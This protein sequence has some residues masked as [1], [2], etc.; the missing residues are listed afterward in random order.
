MAQLDARPTGDQKVVASTPA[1]SATFFLGDLDRNIFYGPSLPFRK[2]VVSFWRKRAHYWLTAWT[3]AC[4]VKVW[5]DK[6]T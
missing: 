6:L 5:L 2:A 1:G 3:T 4:P